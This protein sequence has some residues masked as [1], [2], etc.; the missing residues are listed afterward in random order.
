[1]D[2][3]SASATENLYAM[4]NVVFREESKFTFL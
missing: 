3:Q 2:A 4:V 1:M